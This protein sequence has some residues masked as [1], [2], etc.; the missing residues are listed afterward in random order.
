M[1]NPLRQQQHPIAPDMVLE[2]DRPRSIGDRSSPA[3]CGSR[4]GGG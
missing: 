1:I 3:G 4:M 2:S